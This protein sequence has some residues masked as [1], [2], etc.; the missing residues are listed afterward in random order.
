MEIP[1]YIV[2][3]GHK[4]SDL[5]KKF[6]KEFHKKS[7]L[8]KRNIDIIDEECKYYLI[9]REKKEDEWNRIPL[10]FQRHNLKLPLRPDLKSF[11]LHRFKKN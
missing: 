6:I 10:E 11:K 8:P 2:V 5:K 9:Y 1:G 7:S 3:F 4:T